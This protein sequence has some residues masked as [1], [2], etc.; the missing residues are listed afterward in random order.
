[1]AKL[2]GLTARGPT[3]AGGSI[4]DDF[5]GDGLPDLF[6]TSL[7]VDRPASLFVN[8]GNGRFEDR[9]QSAGLGKQ[10][11][12]LNLARADFDNDGNLD[13]LLLRG[14][15]ESLAP[16]SLLRNSGGG[17]FEDVTHSSGLGVPI[18][19]ESAA[20][21]DFNNDGQV[22]VF[23]CGEFKRSCE[24]SHSRHRPAKPMPALPQSG[25]RQVRGCR[26]RCRSD[27]RAVR[28]RSRLGRLR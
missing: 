28:Q 26:C 24:I 17:V 25:K 19:S 2:V 22:D 8:L 12:A 11:Y 27:Q 5:T 4:F 6:T 13:V 10:I 9:A 16:L 21:G 15:W 7:D 14:G 18:A 23:V 20:W 1:M 3:L